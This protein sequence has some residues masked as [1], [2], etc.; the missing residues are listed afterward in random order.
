VL[1]F[2]QFVNFNE[3]LFEFGLDL[4]KV[5]FNLL[6]ALKVLDILTE[7]LYQF[8]VLFLVLVALVR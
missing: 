7:L 6:S 1:S 8:F 3:H 5:A 2:L 4:F